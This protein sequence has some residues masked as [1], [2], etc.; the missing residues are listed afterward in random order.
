MSEPRDEALDAIR[1][2]VW[3]GHYD[4]EE[5]ARDGFVVEWDGTTESRFLFKGFRWQRRS[6]GAS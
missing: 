6:P 2:H 5:F 1:Y 4:R 3:S